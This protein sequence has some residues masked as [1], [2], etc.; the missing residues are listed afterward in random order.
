M[1]LIMISIFG[2]FNKKNKTLD[3]SSWLEANFPGQLETVHDV[4]DLNPKNLFTKEK[5][6]IV[7]LKDDPETQIK[8][9]WIKNQDDLNITVAEI[10]TLLARSKKDIIAARGILKALQEN[11]TSKISVGVIDMALYVLVFEEPTI[12][13]RKNY[14]D[15]ILTTI[16]NLPNHEQTSIWIEYLEPDTYHVNFKDIIPYGYWHRGDNYHRDK[17]IMALDFEWSEGLEPDRLMSNWS[18]NTASDRSTVYRQEAFEAASEW[19]TKNMPIPFYLESTQM[20]MVEP[21]HDDPMGIRFHFPY[22]ASK[23]DTEQLGFE[24]NALGY[25][26]GVY[27]VDQKTFSKITK[28]DEL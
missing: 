7:A 9:T 1:A 14:L 2:C 28:V 5:A 11:G 6:T 22:F 19:S 3:L 13:N 12:E 26:T 27:Q 8:V 4:I 24:K 16:N 25:V 21:D 18:T 15:K 23:P 17:T 10:D 20:V